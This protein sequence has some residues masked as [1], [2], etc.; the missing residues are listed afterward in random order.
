MLIL[1]C[2]WVRRTTADERR[3]SCGT[4]GRAMV[5]ISCLCPRFQSSIHYWTNQHTWSTSSEKSIV[6]EPEDPHPTSFLCRIQLFT[7]RI[8][9]WCSIANESTTSTMKW[10]IFSLFAGLRLKDFTKYEKLPAQLY[11]LPC[12]MRDVEKSRLVWTHQIWRF[13][14]TPHA[15]Y[16]PS[17]TA[18]VRA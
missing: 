6:V 7:R 2:R 11:T 14:L 1:L 9:T 12:W 3:L 10:R 15:S 17:S 18:R 5:S 8:A 4:Y 16:D 13:R